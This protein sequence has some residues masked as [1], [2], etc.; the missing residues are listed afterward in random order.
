MKAL[1]FQEKTIT[2][3]ESL[4]GRSLIA[5]DTGLG[6]TATSL[7]YI[8]RRSLG[9]TLPALII[10]PKIVRHQWIETIEKILGIHPDILE[11][12]KPSKHS[13]GQIAVINYDIIAYWRDFLEDQ[14][15]RTLIL[16]EV[17]A[18]TNP[19]T[20]RT[21]TATAL[22]KQIP[23]CLALS[24]TP[25]TNRPIELFPVINAL[26]PGDWPN[27]NRYAHR[28]CNPKYTRFGWDFNGA[29]N[30]REL[31]LLLKKSCMIRYRVQDVLHELPQ[32]IR[33]VIP[34]EL[35]KRD[36]YDKANR[37]FLGWIKDNYPERLNKSIKAEAV[38]KSGHLLRLT[39]K[40][41]LKS[42]VDW[43]N[44]WLG[45]TEDQK[46]VIFAVHRKCIQA[47]KRRINAKSVVIDGSVIGK[48]RETAIAQFQQD[49]QT[50]VLIGNIAAAGIGLNLFQASVLTV[51]ELPPKPG[52]LLQIE[53][54]IHRMGQ[55][56]VSWIYYFIGEN[57]IEEKVSKQIQ[58][59]QR[60]ITG[61]LDGAPSASDEEE[62]FDLFD[63]YL[64]EIGETNGHSARSKHPLLSCGTASSCK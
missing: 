47:L 60:V 10:C 6:K 46:I 49:K 24:A 43:H 22:A 41:K 1:P 32:K 45:N 5:N 37:D 9:E 20:K 27:R 53:G 19:K 61:V 12:R 3:T 14:N 18:Y 52:P 15:F 21:R 59:K 42:V 57:T 38:V 8:K 11:T 25:L 17:Q 55:K 58:R 30:I 28:Y 16:D 62:G 35:R 39:A 33:T 40:L 13:V 63:M 48:N 23:Y 51:V 50:R 29:S 34:V 36:Q 7:W 64:E 31:H 44:H 56:N 2:T 26:K 54:R 4:G